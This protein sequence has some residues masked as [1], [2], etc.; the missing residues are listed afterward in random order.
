MS[1]NEW[2]SMDAENYGR[3]NSCYHPRGP[4][5]ERFPNFQIRKFEPA[6]SMTALLISS[7]D[8]RANGG[9]DDDDVDHT[10][11]RFSNSNLWI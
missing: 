11:G 9:N 3:Q 8:L 7:D 1:G 2:R 4:I 5:A 10:V 6:L